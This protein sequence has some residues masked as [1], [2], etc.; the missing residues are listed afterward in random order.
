MKLIAVTDDTHSIEELVEIIGVIKGEMDYVQ[1]REKSK[2]PK[3]LLTLVREL[4]ISGVNKEQMI[5]NDRLDIALLKGIP[6]LHLPESGIPVQMVKRQFP[7]L[8]VGCSVHSVERAKEMEKN[9]A[10]YVV[11]GHC[12][13]TNSKKGIPPNGIEHLIQIKEELGIPV[14]AIG[15]ITLD[16][17]SIVKAARADGIAVMSRIFQAENPAVATKDF[18]E[19]LD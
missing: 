16:N 1:L 8:R 10:D 5:I 18:Q 15:G 3:E 14:Y 7:T 12:F 4:E 11:Y 9:G 19:A 13:E 2:S 17:V 6:T